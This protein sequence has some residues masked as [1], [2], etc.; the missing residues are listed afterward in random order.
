[1]PNLVRKGARMPT[2][3]TVKEH[4]D[5]WSKQKERTTSVLSELTFN[6]LEREFKIRI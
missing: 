3:I 6:D 5:C 2:T 1:M 4:I